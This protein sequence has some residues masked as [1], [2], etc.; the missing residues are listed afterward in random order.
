M[1]KPSA[2][3][4]LDDV[5]SLFKDYSGD[6]TGGLHAIRGF[7]FQVWQAVL[8]TLRAHAT[9]D[10]YAVV[11]E[12]QQDIALL[13]SSTAPTKITFIQLKKN[14]SSHHWTL[15]ALTT[16]GAETS[17]AAGVLP[18][19]DAPDAP[20]G[21]ATTVGTPKLSKAK[22]S[23]L[24][25]LY[26]HRRRFADVTPTKL[27]FASNAPFYVP[28]SDVEGSEQTLSEVKLHEL[29][30]TPLTKV[31]AA[32]SK[33]LGVPSSEPIDL[34]DF[35]LAV[36]T[37]PTE[38][39]HKFAIGELVELCALKKIEPLVTAPFAA[40][41]LIASYINQRAGKRTFAMDFPTLLGRAV[42]RTDVT[43]YLAA[44]NDSHVST[45][46]L[47]DKV[48]ARLNSEV[49]DFDMIQGMEAQLNSACAEVT[50]RAS[51]VWP[52]IEALAQLHQA[53]NGYKTLG[54]HL[55]IRFPAWLSDLRTLK[56]GEAKTFN[57]GYLYCLMA[58]IIQNAKPVQHLSATTSSSK[59]EASQ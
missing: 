6:E 39:A 49:A 35:S 22:Q 53:N 56:F 19:S 42:T 43:L 10:D 13:D 59:P 38:D 41:C 11:L 1:S 40:V 52:V 57:D 21:L 24:A 23:I 3:P 30:T 5:L 51:M 44:A 12:W 45:Q 8:E 34:H 33:Q 17:A 14:E 32:I 47:V 26:F 29:P 15:H 27:I 58:M 7:N 50:N 48:I 2:S 54:S 20:Q 4:S 37:C 16:V 28:A 9:G 36:T 46:D 18:H 31:T 25:K 55:S